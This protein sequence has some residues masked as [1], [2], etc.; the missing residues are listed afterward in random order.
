MTSTNAVADTYSDP[1][2]LGVAEADVT[3]AIGIAATTR[4]AVLNRADG[5]PRSR[6]ATLCMLETTE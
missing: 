5:L 6:R 2:E 3:E 4:E 1:E